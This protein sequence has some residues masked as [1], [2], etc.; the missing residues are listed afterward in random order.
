[1]D[2]QIKR[3]SK[4]ELDAYG[5]LKSGEFGLCTDTEDLYIGTGTENLLVNGGGGM[6]YT[7]IQSVPA[8]VWTVQLPP[9]F[10]KIPNIVVY[11]SAGSRIYGEEHYNEATRTATITYTAA[12]SGKAVF[13]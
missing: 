13:S 4:A 5:P 6:S 2:I 3:G 10:L 1:M 7:H 8:E 9:E 12:F 11:D